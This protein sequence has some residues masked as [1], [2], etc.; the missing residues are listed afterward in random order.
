MTE[1]TPKTARAAPPP[2]L[3]TDAFAALLPARGAL[4]GLDLG[5]KTIG[6]ALS[7]IGRMIASGLVTIERTKFKIDAA[8]LM[9]LVERH[10]S[11]DSS[12]AC[13]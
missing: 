13:R 9:S 1:P 2:E 8:E 3:T 5:S 12:S 4:L 6:L 7:D 10:R 11:V